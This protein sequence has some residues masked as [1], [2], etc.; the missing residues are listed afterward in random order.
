MVQIEKLGAKSYPSTT[1]FAPSRTPTSSIVS[2][3][4]SAAWR[5]NTSE[6]PGSTPMPDER[7]EPALLPGLGP[8]E[9]LVAELRPGLLVG[10]LGMRL[11]ERHRHVEVRRARREGALEHRH[12]EAGIDRVQDRVAP[13]GGGKLGDGLGL[14]R[15]HAR[16]GETAVAVPVDDAPRAPLIVVGEDDVLGE[17]TPGDDRRECRPNAAGPDD[18]DPHGRGV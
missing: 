2:N 14:V 16:G 18:Q 15:I 1:R 3:S 8:R 10:A 17:V 7:E 11:R 6:S 9:L 13:V 4:S 5:A 12:H